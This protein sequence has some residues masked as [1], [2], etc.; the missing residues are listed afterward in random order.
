[1]RK[2]ALKAIISAVH[3]IESIH[4]EGSGDRWTRKL[5]LKF[6]EIAA[7]KVKYSLC[8]HPSLAKNK[9]H[10][11]IYTDWII[12]FRLKEEEFEICR[13]IYGDRLSS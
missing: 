9:Y 6:I 2:R 12:V 8:R 3:Y 4:T 1:M 7:S 13:F 5:K 10:C 11:Y